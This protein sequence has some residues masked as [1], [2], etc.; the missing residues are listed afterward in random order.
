MCNKKISNSLQVGYVRR[1]V[2]TDGKENGLKVVEMDNGVLR[3]L[4]NE[5]KALDVMQVFYKGV[6]MSFVSKNG[7]QTREL[8]FLKRFEGGMI[9]TCGLDSVGDREGFE[10]HGSFHSTPAK[11]VEIFQSENELLVRAITEITSLGGEN[12]YFER[13]VTLCTGTGVLNI[14]DKL[15]NNG[16]K[17]EDY[18]LLYH[19]NIGYPMLDEGVEIKGDFKEIIPRTEYSKTKIDNR[20]VFEAPVDNA[21]ESCYFILNNGNC[22]SVTNKKIGKKLTVTYSKETLPH[23]VQWNNPVTQAYALGIEPA[24]TFLDDKFAY[25]Q[26]NKGEAIDFFVQL[27]FEEV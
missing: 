13:T 23:L 1:Y 20:A 12:L 5:S 22:V 18:C 21:D 4:L 3:V 2:L 17:Q 26:I 9:Y 14:N 8:P 6:N 27:N 24:T 19:I 16:T 11:I 25:R 15:I 7:F 10:P